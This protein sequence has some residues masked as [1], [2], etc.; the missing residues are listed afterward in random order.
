LTFIA[1][2]V[3]LLMKRSN[4]TFNEVITLMETFDEVTDGQIFD[5]LYG[6]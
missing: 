2:E 4:M 5:E 3:R 1:V 6:F